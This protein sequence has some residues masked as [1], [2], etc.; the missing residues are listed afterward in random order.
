MNRRRPRAR[1]VAEINRQSGFGQRRHQG[2]VLRR[3]RG[4]DE[5]VRAV[6]REWR[7]GSPRVRRLPAG[8]GQA[9]RRSG[10]KLD[11]RRGRQ[12]AGSAAPETETRRRRTTPDCP[13]G[14]APAWRRA[15]HA[16]SAG[17]GAA[18]LARTTGRALPLASALCTRS[19]SPTE[20]PPVVTSMSAS[21]VARACARPPRYPRRGRARCRDR[22]P[23]RLRCGQGAQRKAVGIDDLAGRGLA[24]GRHQFVAG[25]EHGDLRPAVHRQGRVVHGGGEHQIAGGEAAALARAATRPA[26]KSMPRGAHVAAL[27]GRLFDG[28]RVAVARGQFLDHHGVGCLSASRRR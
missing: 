10:A 17:R 2:T 21:A 15:G 25:A 6:Q 19:C 4:R 26:L 7:A 8:H 3:Q 9:R 16:S 28:D 1:V 20:A 5:P 27:G 18:P 12:A 14:R 23:R 13:A 11:V 24:A 22:S